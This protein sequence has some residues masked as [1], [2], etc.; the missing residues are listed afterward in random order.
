[1]TTHQ[2]LLAFDFGLKRTG[3]A[4][5]N[6]I[7]GGARPLTTIVAEENDKRFAAVAALLEEWKPDTLLVGLPLA[8]DGAETE[9]SKRARR[10]GNQLHGR[11]GLPVEFVD[12]RYSSAVA[13]DGLKP[14]RADKEKIDAAAAAIILQAWLDQRPS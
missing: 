2:T 3:V 10:F 12:E 13:E 8:P 14:R 6:T 11:F 1:M 5:G 9:I 7:S 4:V